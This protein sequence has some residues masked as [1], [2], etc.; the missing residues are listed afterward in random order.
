MGSAEKAP[1]DIGD[2]DKPVRKT[3]GIL[4]RS[5]LS[6][7]GLAVQGLARFIYTIFIGRFVGEEALADASALLSVSVWMAL[8][9]PSGLG[10]AASRY[11]P[12]AEYAGSAAR[13]LNRWF[14]VSS[15]VL[16]IV[17]IPV[18]LWLV[19]D[20]VAALCC[21]L[22]VFAY[23]AY[24]YTRGAMMGEDRILRATLAD[25]FS[26]IIAIT[27]LVLVLLG[28]MPW[29]LL[30]PLALGFGVFALT[31]RPRTAPQPASPYDRSMFM[32]FVRDAVIGGLAI[33]GLLP[34]TMMFVRAF[35]S[36]VQAGL[37]AAALSLAT[38][39]NMIAQAMNQVL[40]P[41][42][43]RI[44][45]DPVIML[46][47]Q[48]KILLLSTAFFAVIFG[49][50]VV[51]A[52]WI[53]SLLYGAQYAGGAS[54]MQALLGIV[55]LISIMCSPAAYLVASGRQRVYATI[56]LT[57]LIIGT[58]TMVV[59]AP[60][61]GMWGAILGYAI[62]GGGGALA[63]VLYGCFPPMRH[64]RHVEPSVEGNREA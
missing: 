3:G 49:T 64:D 63:A 5:V 24:V 41:H 39:A 31:T 9:L 48:R 10:M 1:A 15:I 30:L 52:P 45:G 61:L 59:A 50:L 34:L 18:S 44:S 19:G 20:L 7:M 12:V 22:L 8:M 26:S 33:G 51:L 21:A 6:T 29:A 40:V 53:L 13:L 38:P 42:F 25:V 56:W 32:R 35:D 23:N 57:S 58:L 27:A 14:W 55:F 11:F 17:S 47:S 46:R 28:G 37:F 60:L 2:G 16:S 36:P 43:A 4:S 54:A 62:G